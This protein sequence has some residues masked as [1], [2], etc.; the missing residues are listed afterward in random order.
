[1]IKSDL[2]SNRKMILLLLLLLLLLPLR[3][4]RPIVQNEMKLLGVILEMY[5]RIT[6]VGGGKH[7]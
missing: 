1:M 4:G 2:K 5:C 6:R 3:P 7:L